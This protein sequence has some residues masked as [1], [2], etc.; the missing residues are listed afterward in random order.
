M[1]ATAPA[2]SLAQDA[3]ASGL[4]RFDPLRMSGTPLPPPVLL[5]CK[6]VVLSLIVRGYVL[7]LPEPFLPMLRVFDLF[8][9]APFRLALMTVFVVA[10]TALVFNVRVRTSA[11]LAGTVF[12]LEPLVSRVDFYYGN[13]FCG[14][15]LF[16]SSL[17]HSPLGVRLVQA[18][19]VVMYFGSG[20]NKLLDPDWRDGHYF[21]YWMGGRTER[22]DFF[23]NLL[24]P[25]AFALFMSW[26]TIAI[27]LALPLLLAR[28]S[29]VRA[30]VWL[31]ILFHTSSMLRSEDVV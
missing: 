22:Y 13:F 27:E 9:R 17:I 29:N 2:P 26:T 11:F 31:A 14:A 10:A 21:Q 28:R 3:P 5:T 18:Q 19:F 20:L 4:A 1:S 23:A 7:K 30:G 8:P 6:L 12:L 24:P 25:G 15:I 16:L